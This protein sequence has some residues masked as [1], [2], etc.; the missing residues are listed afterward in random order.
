MCKQCFESLPDK[1]MLYGLEL[2]DTLI[3]YGDQKGILTPFSLFS[4][5]GY[6]SSH[7][8]DSVS[9]PLTS[10]LCF[11]KIIPKAPK[12]MDWNGSVWETEGVMQVRHDGDRSGLKTS[13]STIRNTRC[14]LSGLGK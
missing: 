14:W 3:L 12:A 6:P 4:A 11:R 10:F 13:G 9:P 1:I 5:S 7:I 8:G 2:G